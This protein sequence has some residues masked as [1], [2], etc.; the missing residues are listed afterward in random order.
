MYP[1]A[2]NAIPYVNGHEHAHVDPAAPP[3]PHNVEAEQALLGAILISNEAHGRVSTFLQPEHFSEPVHRRIYEAAATLIGFGKQATP[4]TL[5]TFFQTAEPIAQG[6]TVPQYL[7]SLAANVTTIINAPDYG[8]IIYDLAKR[9]EL[10]MACQDAIHA[11]CDARPEVSSDTLA[12]A[13]AQR[14]ED[15]NCGAPGGLKPVTL[16][17]LFAADLKPREM[18]LERL[19]PERGI[20]M[21]YG[22]RG[23]SKTWVALAM[24]HAIAAGAT[25]LRW[26]ATQPRRVLHVCGE[27]P[28]IA[29]RERLQPI[30]AGG[31]MTPEHYRIL[32]ADLHEHGLPDLSSPEGQAA[33]DRVLGDTEVLILDNVSTLMRSGV[34]NEAE[35]WLPVQQWLLKL[36]RQ[37]RSV[38]IIH[39]ANKGRAQR[40]TSRREDILDVVLNLR[41]PA[42]YDPSEGARFEVHYEKARGLTGNV[43]EPFEAKLE[44]RDGRAIWAMRDLEDSKFDDI[45][46][47]RAEGQTIRQI[48]AALGMSKSAVQ[49]AINKGACTAVPTPKSG[50]AGQTART[51]DR[52]RDG[53]GTNVSKGQPNPYASARE[54]GT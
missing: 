1:Q 35:S 54:D 10:V 26:Q 43:V 7:G 48:A 53:T 52:G 3:L 15:L 27:M 47:L 51:W 44:T 41:A 17:T 5:Q 49:R 36:R 13:L 9:R 40:G 22:W 23:I 8:G 45:A 18:I 19:L 24:G 38:I 25:F 29:L 32:S 30:A 11:A 12:R 14:L 33:V 21:V 31:A 37:G 2:H 42:D 50:T 16:E 20:M 4:I 34:E 28:A 39:H 46:E 6:L